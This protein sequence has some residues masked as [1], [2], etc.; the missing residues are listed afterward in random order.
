MLSND[1]T[2]VS[3]AVAA[4]QADETGKPGAV[5][6]FQRRLLGVIEQPQ[7]AATITQRLSAG[8]A[9]ALLGDPRDFDEM[10]AILPGHYPL[11]PTGDMVAI[12]GFKIGKY[13]V[14]DA[15]YEK[16]LTANDAVSP[17][18]HW[19]GRHCPPALAN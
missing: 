4:I 10:I 3:S 9:L 12:E 15:Q 11:G 19:D 18:D 13:P 6:D 2:K 17:P 8:L 1:P 14:T 5:A 7:P 16:F